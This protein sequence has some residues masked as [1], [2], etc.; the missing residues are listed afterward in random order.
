MY[1]TLRLHDEHRLVV[2]PPVRRN[3]E[4][5]RPDAFV[6]VASDG[7]ASWSRGICRL[8]TRKSCAWQ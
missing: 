4:N 1:R 6:L 3:A 5:A 7:V 2:C 8:V